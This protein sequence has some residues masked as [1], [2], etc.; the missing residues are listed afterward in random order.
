MKADGA[1]GPSVQILVRRMGEADLEP[2][3]AIAT[4]L[5]NAPH[6][7]REAYLSALDPDSTPRRIALVA[8]TGPRSS[9]TGGEAAGRRV[10]GYLITS[11]LGRQAELESVAVSAAEQRRGIGRKLFFAMVK[12]LPGAGVREVLLEVRSS[13]QEALDFYHSLGWRETGRRPGYYADP[14]EDAVLMSLNME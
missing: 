11:V 14:E 13:N 5:K 7:P 3:I 1:G 6:W 9:P 10:V 2:V 12:E 4:C 8:E